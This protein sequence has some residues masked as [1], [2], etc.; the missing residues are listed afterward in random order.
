MKSVCA[1]IAIL[2]ISLFSQPLMAVENASWGE[3]KFTMAQDVKSDL[4]AGKLV[5]SANKAGG[6][7]GRNNQ[8]SL[9]SFWDDVAENREY[10]GK[11]GLLKIHKHTLNAT[12]VWVRNP[13]GGYISGAD[14]TILYDKD[15]YSS[16]SISSDNFIAMSNGQDGVTSGFLTSEGGY[17]ANVMPLFWVNTSVRQDAPLGATTITCRAVFYNRNGDTIGTQLKEWT[18][19][20]E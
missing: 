11:S 2:F 19:E 17:N 3:V 15:V 4:P 7:R 14:I 16:C 5:I 13:T 8:P 6:W 9:Q 20:V 12:P 18:E 10:W 1:V